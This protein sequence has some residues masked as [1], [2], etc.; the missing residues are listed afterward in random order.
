MLFTKQMAADNIRN[1]EGRRVFY[2]DKAD[3]LTSEA[4]DW[5]AAQRIE[6][7]PASAARQEQMALL[8]GGFVTEKPEHLTHLNGDVLVSKM[9]PRIRFRGQVDRLEGELL[10]C[11]QEYPHL[12][13]ELAEILCLTRHI[14]RCDVLEEPLTLHALCG[15][16]QEEIRKQSHLPQKYFSVAHFMP[17][18]QDK[19]VVL[20]L[21]RVRCQS[22]ETELAGLQAFSDR[23]GNPTRTDI[24][25]ALN[26]ISSMLYILMLREKA[27]V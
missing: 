8:T 20:A 16:S 12:Q 14:V 4:K 15:L 25:Q 23:E 9:H 27:K 5:L 21:N 22:R 2:L 18:F 6:I 11:G 3:T 26:R 17:D 24:L 10:L 1:R 19:P 7:L 13:E